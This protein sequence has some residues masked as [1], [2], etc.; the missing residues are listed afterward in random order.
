[1]I[2]QE[3]SLSHYGTPRHS[4]R[5]PW[6]SGGD[7][8][9]RN[10]DFLGVYDELKKGG[11]SEV[12]IAQAMGFAVYN[13]DGSPRSSGTTQLRNRKTIAIQEQRAALHAQAKKLKD[14]G[15]GDSAIAREMGLKNESSVRALLKPGQADK[16]AILTAT[17]DHLR[18]QV[19][20]F[21]IVDVG[22][23]AEHYLNISHT[24]LQAAVD[25]LEEEGYL[26]SGFK[27][28]QLG[29]PFETKY[30]VLAAKDY[31][32]KMVWR[33]RFKT[34]LPSGYSTDGGRTYGHDIKYPTSIDSKRVQVLW[35]EEGGD[36]ADGMI[37][38]RRGVDDVSLGHSNYAQ[39]RIAVD[40]THFLKGMAMYKDDLPKGVDLQFNTNKSKHDPK[41]NGD[42][43]KAMKP[44]ERDKTTG[45]IDKERPFGA[46]PLRQHGVM[47]VLNDEGAWGD[48]SSN[49]S[50]QFLSKQNPTFAKQQLEINYERKKSQ[51][52]EI[53]SL[54]NPV[55][56]KK[57][58]EAFADGA[59][60][61]AVNLEA[62]GLPRTSTHIILPS[63]HIKET[64]IY[65]PNYRQGERVALVRHPHGG[66]FEIPNL[67]VNN[68]NPKAKKLLGSMRDA[69]GI[70]P[71][72]ATKLSGA[73]FDGD[74][75][76]VIP[77]GR[78]KVKHE[79]ALE[80][81]KDFDAKASYPEYKGMHIMTDHEKQ[82][83]MGKV[84]NLITDM[85]IKGASHAEL[86]RAIRHSMVVIDAQKHKLNY[87]L[88]EEDNN[89]KQLKKKWQDPPY[90]GAS[91]IVSKAGSSKRIPE[92]KQLVKINPKTGE[93]IFTPTGKTYVKE[94]IDKK[95]GAIT[96]KT[97][98]KT[99]EVDLL[100]VTKN[101]HAL[102]S[103]NPHPVELIYADHSNRLKALANQA[104]KDAY[105]TKTNPYNSSANKAYA[106]EV[107]SLHAA[108]KK[109]QMMAPV[110][111]QAQLVGNAFYK[112][113]LDANPDMP[114]ETR[115]KIKNQALRIGR[116]RTGAKKGL[117]QLTQEEWNAI[118][119]GA[120]S[121][122]MLRSILD[123]ADMDVIKKLATPRQKLL[124]TSSKTAR[125][126]A[127]LANGHTQA[128]VAN[129]LG[130]SL[131]TL[132]TTL[133]KEGI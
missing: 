98:L 114:K 132:K 100:S 63:A 46:I 18:K 22:A 47:N 56:R 67:V 5:Y 121:S 26:K 99:Q 13:N 70:H 32:H 39:V 24:K 31:D 23:G 90:Y 61:S 119:A 8:S 53:M 74:T 59:D 37:Y 49:F 94:I 30:K 14:T 122:T 43:L 54:T 110:E 93:Q 131:T 3:D 133:K 78:G 107:A 12:D 17:A 55:V 125:A 103:K 87:K 92:R 75:V 101:A 82:S 72:T 15:M 128:E 51:Y 1:M 97:V 29:T 41:I 111:R 88:S 6:G 20:K 2:I 84:S 118:Q 50:S 7:A 106:K 124:M 105:F 25:L 35:K 129:A 76:L 116:E 117:I 16:N 11:M 91:T 48:W 95:T 65:A 19:D 109:A 45:R 73:D 36:L 126:K 71:K 108:L 42:K 86:A 89:I 77:N 44:L 27:I 130:V 83:E 60:S 115:K 66:I 120:I 40:G 62:A 9:A 80:S 113:R 34:V 57:L 21:K 79:P 64:E 69:V 96:N 123:T 112:T 28:P 52:E 68:N 38:V 127:M 104:R 4:G 10:R 102:V 85:T 33:D 58:L 81:L